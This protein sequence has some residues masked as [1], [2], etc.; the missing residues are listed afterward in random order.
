MHLI[1]RGILT[2]GLAH[3]LV[4]GVRAD[5]RAEAMSLINKALESAGGAQ[6]LAKA[7][8]QTW[9]EKGTYFGMGEG[10]PFTSSCAVQFP[11][12]FKM[13]IQGFFL[14]V[15]DGE[16]GW[17]K[18]NGETNE[19]KGDELKEQRESQYAGWVAS[20]VPLSDEAFQLKPLGESN[21]DDQPVKGVLVSRDGHR[22]VKLFVS[23]T[24][25]LLVKSEFDVLASEQA[26]KKVVQEVFYDD[27]QEVD[28]VKMPRKVTIKHDGKKFVEAT[29]IELKTAEKL[30][31]K[32]FAKP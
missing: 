22:D 25:G 26:G 15:L 9:T 29:I 2:L 16:I 24:S 32:V 12:R 20:L 30:D 27:H 8:A 28:G 11:G 21:I 5:D 3:S 1:L 19:L 13:E 17:M 18:A 6:K 7:R 10:V 23:D 14:I 4:V 31:D